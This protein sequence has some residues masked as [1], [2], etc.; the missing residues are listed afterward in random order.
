MA[1]VRFQP[2]EQNTFKT[3]ICVVRP[4]NAKALKDFTSLGDYTDSDLMVPGD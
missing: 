3:N 2:T 1:L 4:A